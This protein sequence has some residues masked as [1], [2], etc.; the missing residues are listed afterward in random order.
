MLLKLFTI[1]TLYIGVGWG[2][3]MIELTD[4]GGLF[5]NRWSVSQGIRTLASRY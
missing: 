3:V 1:A 5:S 4:I 2:Y